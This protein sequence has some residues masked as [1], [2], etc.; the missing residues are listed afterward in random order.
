MMMTPFAYQVIDGNGSPAAM[1]ARVAL[2][3]SITVT[4]LV[5]VVMVG[6]TERSI[7]KGERGK[8]EGEMEGGVNI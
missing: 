2:A 8:E 5:M 7:A 4:E 3:P 1:Q 6:G